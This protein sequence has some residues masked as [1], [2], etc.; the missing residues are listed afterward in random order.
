MAGHTVGGV[1]TMTSEASASQRGAFP[2]F[3]YFPKFQ[4]LRVWTQPEHIPKFYMNPTLHVSPRLVR[5]SSLRENTCH[6][7]TDALL[8]ST[9]N[10]VAHARHVSLV[11]HAQSLPASWAF[12]QSFERIVA[13]ESR[14][15]HHGRQSIFVLPTRV[16]NDHDRV[17]AIMRKLAQAAQ[18]S[19]RI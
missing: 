11:S 17:S 7:Q 12:Y 10:C 13:S 16:K 14:R 4:C 1:D 8:V 2:T 15:K 18:S 19:C 9:G 5:R 3:E 6:Q